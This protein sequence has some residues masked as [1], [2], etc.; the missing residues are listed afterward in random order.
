MAINAKAN[1][2]IPQLYSNFPYKTEAKVGKAKPAIL[3]RSCGA[4][5]ADAVYWVYESTT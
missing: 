4:A 5:I 2:L 3:R 1:M